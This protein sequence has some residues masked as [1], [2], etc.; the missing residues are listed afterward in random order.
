[1]ETSITD[2]NPTL[3]LSRPDIEAPKPGML[4]K[5]EKHLS[6]P[7]YR[8]ALDAGTIGFFLFLII[9]PL[10]SIIF[11]VIFNWNGIYT[12]VFNDPITGNVQ[13][14]IM[15]TALGRSFEI[16]TIATC[17]DLL[18]GLP[19]AFILTRYN[20]K[21]RKILDTLVD[22]PMAVPTS[23][24]GFS[25]YLFWGTNMGL[26]GLL[27]LQTG[28]I[29]PGPMLITFTHVAFTYPFIVRNLKVIFQETSK[30]YEDA[31]KTLGA[32]GFTVFRTVTIPLAKE[33]ILAGIILAFT[34]S[35]GETGATI[36]V[37]GVF[38]T[39]PVYVVSLKQSLHFP[40]AAFLS[41]ILISISLIA[42]VFLRVFAR[43]VGFPISKV[44]PKAERKLSTKPAR[45]SRNVLGLALFVVIVLVPALYTIPFVIEYFSVNPFTH[46][47]TNTVLASLFAADNKWAW[48]WVSSITS[49]EIASLATV[50]CVLF[51]LPMAMILVK[52][53]WGRFKDLLDA[54]VD[55]PLV[56]PTAALGF[57]MYLFWG[58]M[59][60]NVFQPGFWLIILVHVAMCFPYVVRPIVAIIQKT[61]PELEDAART[62]G[63]NSITTFR[64]ITLPR[65]QPGIVAGMIMS[66]TR[67]M[68]ETG[69]TI[70]VSGLITTV[71]LIIVQ[72]FE[73]SS[74]AAAG[75]ASLILIL[76][77]FIV[78][79]LLRKTMERS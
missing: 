67:S 50:I 15:F 5:I 69:A 25:L 56:A 9:G 46:D 72:W 64:T 38:E 52:R 79:L 33:G 26:S 3:E 28:I 18:L 13:G 62:L 71:P 27:G 54:L 17:I 7:G 59:G 75:F 4:L 31:A 14:Q 10:F 24:L 35:L 12:S 77:S 47:S 19:M 48:L 41:M 49:L 29:S 61:D 74:F 2:E 44:W 22:L 32:P 40:A 58:P 45:F 73:T 36:I 8:K 63:A 68:G 42:L 70:V 78:L 34:R 30:T 53:P 60:L 57:A 55:V 20:F 6:K 51:G 37:A 1:M 65:M 23:A 16:A 21:G 66:F 11:A 43:R 39:A 76:F